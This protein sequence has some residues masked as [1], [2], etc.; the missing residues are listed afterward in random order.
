MFAAAVVAGNMAG[1][2]ASTLNT[3]SGGYLVS[4]VLYNLIYISNETPAAAN[5]RSIVFVSGI[6]M[7]MTLFVKAGNA[8][9]QRSF[10]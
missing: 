6:G 9:S 4:R 3:L 1:L 10:V 2:G 5:T 8:L 7:I